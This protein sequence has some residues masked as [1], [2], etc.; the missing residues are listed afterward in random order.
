MVAGDLRVSLATSP[1]EIAEA[2]ALR[3]QVFAREFGAS[4]SGMDHTM[5]RETDCFDQVAHHLILRDHA[6]GGRVLGTYRMMQM[7]HARDAGGF[8]SETEFDL[9][10]LHHS[11]RTLCE[12][13]RSCLHPD[14]RGGPGLLVLWKGLEDYVHAN[15]IDL[16]FGVAS[17]Q[18]VDINKLN[19]ALSHLHHTHLAPVALRPV[20]LRPAAA[21]LPSD[22]IDRKAAMRQVPPL[23]KNYLRK[24]GVIGQGAF[25][26]HAFNTT[27]ICM[28]LDTRITVPS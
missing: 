19:P 10:A 6:Q 20:S 2:Q 14:A 12:L 7:A 4:T 18:G 27:D 3:Y 26:D 8:Y 16:L 13:S 22:Q 15:G 25:V 5:C 9:S 1:D 23:I 11:G 17:F 21:P 24:G 28:V